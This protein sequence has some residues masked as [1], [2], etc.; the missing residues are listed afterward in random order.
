MTKGNFLRA[1]SLQAVGEYERRVI[2]HHT[3]DVLQ[4]AGVI[5]TLPTPL[6]EVRRA[7]GITE[8][9]DISELPKDIATNKPIGLSRIIGAF[10]FRQRI[11]FIDSKLSSPRRRFTDAHEITHSVLPAHARA[12]TL[13]DERI[14]RDVEEYLDLEANVGATYLLFQGSRFHRRAL[15]YPTSIETPKMMAESY[16][17]SYH[18]TIRFYVE[19]HPEPLALVI[20]GQ[21]P[22][23]GGRLPVWT[24]CESPSFLERYG[25]MANHVG[26]P[27]LDPARDSNSEIPFAR[28]TVATAVTKETVTEEVG[29]QDRNGDRHPF[30][31]QAWFNQRVHFLMLVPKRRIPRG[32]R[33]TVITR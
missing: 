26:R 20:T 30:F 16:G 15:Q 5:G 6:D 24:W 32:R 8:V 21:F 12:Y 19:N 10:A 25:P 23:S 33:I 11:V 7:A 1:S 14:F 18:A 4:R 3:E 2:L 22:Q 9:V 13:D 28:L 27:G 29:L 31:A 17:T